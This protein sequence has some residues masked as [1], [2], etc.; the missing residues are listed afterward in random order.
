MRINKFT[1]KLSCVVCIGIVI[2]EQQSKKASPTY[3][4]I[5]KRFD[6][7]LTECKDLLPKYSQKEVDQIKRIVL[8]YSARVFSSQGHAS[9]IFTSLLLTMIEDDMP[10][11]KDPDVYQAFDDLHASIRRMHNYWDR[12]LDKEHYYKE[13]AS[14]FDVWK[15]CF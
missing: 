14:M 6:K 10:K 8:D 1:K 4:K 3:Q 11:I 9:E 13:A 12:K 7:S 15:W 2:Y 5:L